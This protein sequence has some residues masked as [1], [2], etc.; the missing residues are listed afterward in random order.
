MKSLSIYRSQHLLVVNAMYLMSSYK[1]EGDVLFKWK[2]HLYIPFFFI[3]LMQVQTAVP[4]VLIWDLGNTLFERNM[5]SQINA[6]GWWDGLRFYLQHGFNSSALLRSS[7][8]DVMRLYKKPDDSAQLRVSG[9][10]D[11]YGQPLPELMRA[12]FAGEKKSGEVLAIVKKLINTYTGFKSDLHKRIVGKIFDWMF[13]PQMYGPSW[14]PSLQGLDL[15][16]QTSVLKD[17]RGNPKNSSAV[18][19]NFD[20]HTFSIVKQNHPEV[21]KR[22]KQR[23]IFVSGQRNDLKPSPS[24]FHSLLA[25]EGVKPD[26][27]VL[28]DDQKENCEAA[29]KLGMHAFQVKDGNFIPVEKGLRSLGI[30]P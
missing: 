19:S 11:P 23:S 8:L 18:L 26:Q 4:Y 9:A 24:F 28:I 27:A 12:W 14:Q 15:L 5:L 29:R 2:N 13:T 7:L 20:E 17:A 25:Q 21:F 1:R 22:F 16:N 30:V 10:L 3:G 6:V